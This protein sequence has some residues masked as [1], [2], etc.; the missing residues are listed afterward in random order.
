MICGGR[1]KQCLAFPF[2]KRPTQLIEMQYQ[3]YS[4]MPNKQD[5]Y[6][7]MISYSAL[8]RVG[9]TLHYSSKYDKLS[10]KNLFVILLGLSMK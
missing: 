3:K 8:Y 7:A 2:K 10:L 1:N 6:S 5:D 9:Y 4:S